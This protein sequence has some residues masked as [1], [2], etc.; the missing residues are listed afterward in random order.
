[1]S[2][3]EALAKPITME[4]IGTQSL[5]DAIYAKVMSKKFRKLKVDQAAIEKTKY[6]IAVAVADNKPLTV[7]FLFG[8]NKLWRLDEAPEVDWAELFALTYDLQWMRYIASVYEPGVVLDFYSEELAVEELNNVPRT[9]TAHYTRSF[10]ALLSWMEPYIPDRISVQYRLYADEYSDYSAFLTELEVA[11]EAVLKENGGKLPELSEAQ[12]AA[13]ELNVKL[14]PG[15]DKDPLWREKVELMHQALER[16]KRIEEVYFGDRSLITACPT[17][18]SG[19]IATGSTKRSYAKFWA[20][21]GALQKDDDR[22]RELVLT[23]KQL[24][25]TDFV[26]QGVDIKGLDGENFTK[27]RVCQTNFL[28]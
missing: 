26:W 23:P 17:W 3:V 27:I 4:S 22:F 12:K 28:C 21:A 2:T 24:A 15:Q 7:S 18:Y 14:N 8:G 5:E 6:A 20:A 13:T 16:T 1:M 25:Q 9:D 19:W 10:K 11:K